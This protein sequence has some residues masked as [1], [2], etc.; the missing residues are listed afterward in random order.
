[1]LA[2][3]AAVVVLSAAPF[4]PALGAGFVDLDDFSLL[5]ENTRYQVLTADSLTWMFTTM[6]MGHYMPLTWLSYWL[7]HTLGQGSPGMFHFTNIVLHA[8]NVGLLLLILHR[9]LVMWEARQPQRMTRAT[10]VFPFA[11]GAAALL[12]GIHPLR[13]ESVAWVTERRDVLSTFFLLMA[14][15][16]WL[17]AV[18]ARDTGA[19]VRPPWKTAAYWLAAMFLLLSLLSKSW[20]MSFF[21]ILLILDVFPLRRV[22]PSA[23]QAVRLLVEKT[24]FIVLGAIFAIIASFAQRSAGA[25]RTLD[26]WGIGQRIAQAANGLVFYTHKSLWPSNLAVLYELPDDLNPLAPRYLVC[27]ALVIGAGALLFLMRRRAPGLIAASAVYVLVLS[28]VLGV[29]QSGDQF[30]ADRYSYIATMAWAALLAA[31]LALL[32]ARIQALPSP[33]ARRRAAI[34]GAGGVA[35]FLSLS[36]ATWRQTTVWQD[37][38]SLW[39]HAIEAGAGTSGVHTSYAIA[40]ATAGRE[41]ES[42]E[43][44]VLAIQQRNHNGRAWFMLGHGLQRQGEYAAAAWAY[45]NA[46][47]HMPQAYMAHVNRGNMLMTLGEMQEAIASFRAAVADIER[48][49]GPG[50]GVTSPLPYLALGASLART[51]DVEGARRALTKAHEFPELRAEAGRLL[52]TLPSAPGP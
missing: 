2:L 41:E 6:Y 13:V 12:W 45:Q 40:L 4:L 28:P 35:I 15:L 3:F 37:S 11:A 42:L 27:Y 16:A 36:A 46:A 17:R 19:G 32:A 22:Q 20:G 29:L 43:H 26:E 23:S 39:R 33:H 21:V 49:R 44:L 5:V 8:L 50:E 31:G 24:P 51:G 48:P 52:E 47:L 30:V 34:M 14:L 25:V 10:L 7:D 1:M 18:S 38:L 9:L